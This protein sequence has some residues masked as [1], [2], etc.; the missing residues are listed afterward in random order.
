[1]GPKSLRSGSKKSLGSGGSRSGLGK[2]K[3]VMTMGELM[4]IQMGIFDAMDSRVK[5]ALLRISAAQVSSISVLSH[6]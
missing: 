1:M 3:R 2:P 6:L 4:R 5:R